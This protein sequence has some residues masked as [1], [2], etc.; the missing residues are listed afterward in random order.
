[1]RIMSAVGTLESKL[2]G[3]FGKTAPVQIPENGRKA[4]VEYLPWINVVLGVL[5]LWTALTLW[6]WAHVASDVIDYANSLT[7]VYGGPA[8]SKA[9]L[10]SV[11][12]LGLI[13]L[14]VEGLLLLA[15][16][17]GTRER[18]K[19]GWNLLFYAALINVAY[20]L[21][22]LFSDYGGV[23]RLVST[24]IGSVIGLYFL[25]QIRGY[26]TGQR[27]TATPLPKV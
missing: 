18:K 8:L 17:P 4:I 11:V 22:M 27:T 10:T 6:H 19:S 15:A 21:V 25:F 7:Q 23:G 16:F 12:W 1:M 13:V 26:Y 3:I 5:T 9:R 2:D 20:G 24:L 14:I